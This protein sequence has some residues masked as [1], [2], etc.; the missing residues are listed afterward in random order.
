MRWID[1]W[2]TESKLV[3]RDGWERCR[4]QRWQGKIGLAFVWYTF[5]DGVLVGEGSTREAAKRLIEIR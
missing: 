3:D 2:Q 1:A 5:M 4:V